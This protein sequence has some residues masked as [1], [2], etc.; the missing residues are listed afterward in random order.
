M[1][2]NGNPID[3]LFYRKIKLIDMYGWSVGRTI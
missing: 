2:F 1:D 3:G